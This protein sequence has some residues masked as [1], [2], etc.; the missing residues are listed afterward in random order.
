M[1]AVNGPVSPKQISSLTSTELISLVAGVV[2]PLTQAAHKGQAGRIGVVGGSLEYTGAPYYAAMT[3][4]RMG[5]DLSHVFC[6]RDAAIPIKCYSPELIVHPILDG[7]DPMGE[8]DEWLPRLH[9]LILGPGLGRRPQTFATLGHIIEAAKD[10]QLL[11][12]FDADALFYLNENYDMLQGYTNAILTPNRVEMARLY[13]AVIKND[14]KAEN[15]RSEHVLQV[16]NQLGVTIAC[17]GAQDI[18]ACQDSLITCD[19]PGSPRRCG[20]QGD[21]FSGATA[22][23]LYWAFGTVEA[24]NAHLALPAP[25][26]AAWGASALTRRAASLAFSQKGRGTLSTD[27]LEMVHQAFFSL[28]VPKIK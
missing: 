10:R 3:A 24:C 5:A 15:I 7:N 20:G 11:L 17:K 4:L 9:A 25:M 16:A 1:S 14:M 6:H 12:V 8:I 28:Y 26:L 13:R 19:I 21:L 18:I 23:F 22:V 2:P 27:I